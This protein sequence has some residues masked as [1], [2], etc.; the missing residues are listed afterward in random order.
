MCAVPFGI[1]AIDADNSIGWGDG[2][3]VAEPE[4]QLCDDGA[5]AQ[6]EGSQRTVAFELTADC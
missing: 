6:K 3:F 2:Q 1:S 4:R 5:A